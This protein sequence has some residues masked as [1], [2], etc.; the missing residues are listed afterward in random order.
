MA[1]LG[2]DHGPG[3]RRSRCAPPLRALSCR[4]TCCWCWN[5]AARLA[6]GAAAGAAECR[7]PRGGQAGQRRQQAVY[8]ARQARAGAVAA[9]GAGQQPPVRDRRRPRPR[10]PARPLSGSRPL[11]DPARDTAAAAGNARGQ[12]RR[13]RLRERLAATQINLPHALRPKLEPALREARRSADPGAPSRSRW[14]S[15]SAWSPGSR[16]FAG[17]LIQLSSPFLRGRAPGAKRGIIV[18]P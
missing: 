5:S 2:F 16:R 10:R 13:R 6:A 7:A 8:R 12:D 11:P 17:A 18:R 14:P 3:R 1:A 15:A 4:A 9:R